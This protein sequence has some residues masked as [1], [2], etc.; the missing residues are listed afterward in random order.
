MPEEHGVSQSPAL[1]PRRSRLSSVGE[2]GGVDPPLVQPTPTGSAQLLTTASAGAHGSACRAAAA[3]EA[4]NSECRDSQPPVYL[5]MLPVPSPADRELQPSFPAQSP[6]RTLSLEQRSLA[7]SDECRGFECRSSECRSSECRSSE[8]R[9][10]ECR[11]SEAV[12]LPIIAHSPASTAPRLAH[13]SAQ[14]AACRV[15]NGGAAPCRDSECRDSECR[16]SEAVYLPIFMHT[17]SNK[18]HAEREAAV[19]SGM[20]LGSSSSLKRGAVESDT[21]GQLAC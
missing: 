3:M 20:P 6:R 13:P 21:N 9:S 5:A 10:S 19:E 1:V 8:C 15:T 11:S 16:S 7:A 12:Y 2:S 18:L 4:R 17:T 14:A